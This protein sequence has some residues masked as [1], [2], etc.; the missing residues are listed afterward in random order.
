MD[1]G[2]VIIETPKGSKYKFEA[3]T[4]RFKA[5]KLLPSGLAFPHDFGFIPHTKGGDGDPPDMMIFSEDSFLPGSVV[6]VRYS[7]RSRR[8]NHRMRRQCVTID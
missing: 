2:D 6:E 4:N 3:E 1:T 8:N 7:A 5:H